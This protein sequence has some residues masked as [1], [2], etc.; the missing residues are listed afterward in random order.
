M[1]VIRVVGIVDGKTQVIEDIQVAVPYRVPVEIPMEKA[2]ISKD[3]WRMLGQRL[4]FKL[5]GGPIDRLMVVE[6]APQKLSPSPTPVAVSVVAEDSVKKRLSQVERENES[7]KSSLVE[8]G[9]MLEA[10]LQAVKSP[11]VVQQVVST[12]TS[13]APPTEV[14]DEGVPM[15]IPSQI[16]PEIGDSKIEVQKS[17]TGSTAV[18]EASEKLK[19]LR[20]QKQG[21]Q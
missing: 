3:L 6:E 10:I 20:Q 11:V 5:D 1:A 18:S 16:K 9:R 13:V 7:L 19:K 2:H 21:S 17:A 14:V 12:P 4:I 8:Q 15:F